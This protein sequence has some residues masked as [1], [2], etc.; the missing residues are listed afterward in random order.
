MATLG[1]ILT[2]VLGRSFP[3]GVT[4]VNPGPIGGRPANPVNPTPREPDGR[5]WPNKGGQPGREFPG[6]VTPQPPKGG[7]PGR[8]IDGPIPTTPRPGETPR[9]PVTPAPPSN[10]TNSGPTPTAPGTGGDFAKGQVRDQLMPGG[11]SFAPSLQSLFGSGFNPYA[12]SGGGG[13]G[14]R[15][16]PSQYDPYGIGQDNYAGGP[17][18]GLPSSNQNVYGMTGVNAATGY[19]GPARYGIVGGQGGYGVGMVGPEYS[20]PIFDDATGALKAMRRQRR[21]LNKPIQATAAPA[22]AESGG[23]VNQQKGGQPAPTG[24]DRPGFEYRADRRALKQAKGGQPPAPEA[25]APAA[26]QTPAAQQGLASGL[27]WANQVNG[28]P[29]QETIRGFY[30]TPFGRLTS[31]SGGNAN[32]FKQQGGDESTLYHYDPNQG[33]K[34]MTQQEYRG[35]GDGARQGQGYADPSQYAGAGAVKQQFQ[36]TNVPANMRGF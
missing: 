24:A 32:I 11:G 20:G 3:G 7:Q 33:W 19:A 2:A 31:S 16:F 17:Y 36:R 8:P 5:T 29:G 9:V 25:A 28:T 1:D 22:P 35:Y 27:G 30:D 14:P 23:N 13:G 10:P 4:P 34:S 12:G 18:G 15:D 6:G 21:A 26:P